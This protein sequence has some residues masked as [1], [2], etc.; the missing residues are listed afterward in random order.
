MKFSDWVHDIANRYL[1]AISTVTQD[2]MVRRDWDLVAY[3]ALFQAHEDSLLTD[4]DRRIALEFVEAGAF[5]RKSGEALK[6]IVLQPAL[7]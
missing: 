7:T 6:R 5:D 4:E 2:R 3:G 1:H